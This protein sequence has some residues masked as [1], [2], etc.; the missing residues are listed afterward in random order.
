ME[1][2]EGTF[3]RIGAFALAMSFGVAIETDGDE[4]FD[5]ETCIG[6]SFEIFLRGGGNLTF[7]SAKR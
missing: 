2:R 7:G 4:I 1:G 6:K 3:R 5:E